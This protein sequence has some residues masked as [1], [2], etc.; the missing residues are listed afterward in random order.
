[1]SVVRAGDEKYHYHDG[2]HRW[3]P[4]DPDHD[5]AAWEEQVRQHKLDHLR[6]VRPKVRLRR[7]G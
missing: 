1:M 6:N 5:Q 2:S 3:V 7:I 4:P